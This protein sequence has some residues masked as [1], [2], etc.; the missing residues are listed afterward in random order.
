METR[1]KVPLGLI[2]DCLTFKQS[3]KAS[4]SEILKDL[5]QM[6]ESAGQIRKKSYEVEY[7]KN[8]SFKTFCGR[9]SKL[10]ITE[11]VGPILGLAT[12]MNEMYDPV[13]SLIPIRAECVEEERTIK[14]PKNKK[15]I[16]VNKQ[17]LLKFT[18]AGTHLALA[19]FIKQKKDKIK[20]LRS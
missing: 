7:K 18:R 9:K 6:N 20:V 11:D 4:S 19:F 14:I 12:L 15:T 10:K 13:T 8:K 5:L 2:T 1:H 16:K 3:I 17:N